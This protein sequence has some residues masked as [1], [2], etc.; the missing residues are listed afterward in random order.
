MGR[1]ELVRNAEW[2]DKY[3]VF[4]SK[5][6]NAGD[7][8]PHQIL[9]RPILGNP[10]TCCTETYIVI[11][12]FENEVIAQNVISYIKTKFFRFLVSIRKI[13]QDATQ[14]VYQFVPM[15][16]FTKPCTDADLY[17]KYGLSDDEIAFIENMIKPM[18]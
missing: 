6:Y 18:E 8:Y 12:P 4:L 9:N 1:Q 16:D 3:K 7:E 17:V 15:Q 11:G 14:K 2:V 10:G 5:A 13:S